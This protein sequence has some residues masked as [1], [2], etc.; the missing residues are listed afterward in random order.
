M[1]LLAEL[2][3]VAY[4]TTTYHS[5]FCRAATAAIRQAS[6]MFPLQLKHIISTYRTHDNCNYGNRERYFISAYVQNKQIGVLKGKQGL[7]FEFYEVVIVYFVY[8]F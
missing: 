3:D 1:L 4:D 8:T 7:F 2:T 5:L 6:V